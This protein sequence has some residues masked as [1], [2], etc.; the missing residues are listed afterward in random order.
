VSASE[1]YL[2]LDWSEGGRV[3]ILVEESVCEGGQ[4]RFGFIRS[5]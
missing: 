3:L 4:Q 5:R 1:A 2:P